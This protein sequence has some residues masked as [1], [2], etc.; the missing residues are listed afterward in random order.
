M[1][2]YPEF[3]SMKFLHKSSNFFD[4]T[5]TQVHSQMDLFMV[6]YKKLSNST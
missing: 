3:K 1:D 2:K 5:K 4:E 6:A